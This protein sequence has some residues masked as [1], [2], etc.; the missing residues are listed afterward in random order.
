M[1]LGRC[2]SEFSFITTI[3]P[4]NSQQWIYHKEEQNFSSVQKNGVWRSKHL[5]K[6]QPLPHQHWGLELRTSFGQGVWNST[7]AAQA[8]DRAEQG[9]CS[10]MQRTPQ[11]AFICAVGARQSGHVSYTVICRQGPDLVQLRQRCFP[12][13][14]IEGLNHVH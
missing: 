14:P 8:G 5:L 12:C 6:P 1:P 9:Q 4:R 7:G 10:A 13:I 11:H 3:A 2:V